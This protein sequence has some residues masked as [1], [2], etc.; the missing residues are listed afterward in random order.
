MLLGLALAL[1][2][3]DKI[4]GVAS[5]FVGLAGLA[6]SVLAL[7]RPPKISLPAAAGL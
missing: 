3:D 2:R 1:V 6:L 5:M 7:V 4:T